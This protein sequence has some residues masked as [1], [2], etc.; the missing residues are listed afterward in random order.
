V[1]TG[2]VDH[3][4]GLVCANGCAA[5]SYPYFLPYIYSASRSMS[6]EDLVRMLR[7]VAMVRID[8]DL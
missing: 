1:V 2:V 5:E 3:I 7:V 8:C 4:R 6:D